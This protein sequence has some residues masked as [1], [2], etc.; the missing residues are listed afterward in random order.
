M[1]FNLFF[2]LNFQ[3]KILRKNKILSLGKI[4]ILAPEDGL[5]TKVMV[6][7]SNLVKRRQ[8][9]FNYIL[10][11]NKEKEIEVKATGS[12]KLNKLNVKEGQMF[13]KNDLL[14]KLYCLKERR[15]VAIYRQLMGTK[16]YNEAKV[17]PFE[18]ELKELTE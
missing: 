2:P 4:D 7:K 16:E 17:K 12:G 6:R 14:V 18:F 1:I 3:S 10:D 11:S 13:K 8:H 5:V 15:P 9:L